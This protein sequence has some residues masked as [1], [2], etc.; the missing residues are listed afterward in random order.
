MPKAV[1]DYDDDDG[2]LHLRVP[3]HPG[4]RSDRARQLEEI[5]RLAL[6]EP[7]G[8]TVVTMAPPSEPSGG[9]DDSRQRQIQRIEVIDEFN[10]S[11]LSVAKSLAK[12][13]ISVGKV[14]TILLF[15]LAALTAVSGLVFV[16]CAVFT[17]TNPFAIGASGVTFL[18]ALITTLITSPLQ[19]IERDV[20]F[21]RW[22]DTVRA[23]FLVTVGGD[24]SNAD[25]QQAGINASAQFS[26]L[27][28]KYAELVGKHSSRSAPPN[29]TTKKPL[30][31]QKS[32]QAAPDSRASKIG[33]RSA[34][35]HHASIAEG[36]EEPPADPNSPIV[37]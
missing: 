7:E 33:A 18:T 30:A 31:A 13:D 36:G 2:A 17:S 9:D 35:P 6:A 20:I 21:R 5:V 28:T 34:K 19:T 16:A 11:S 10:E 27:A 8:N 23:T 12:E 3:E 29:P 14:R 37:G 25:V 24:T 22:S 32:L 1:R 26:E 4:E 15:T